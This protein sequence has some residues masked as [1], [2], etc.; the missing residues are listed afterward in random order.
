MTKPT[1]RHEV[2]NGTTVAAT[3]A[4]WYSCHNTPINNI[5]TRTASSRFAP[6]LIKLRIFLCCSSSCSGFWAIPTTAKIEKGRCSCTQSTGT[7]PMAA[8]RI[9]SSHTGSTPCPTANPSQQISKK[10]GSVA[11]PAKWIQRIGSDRNERI[12]ED[13]G[14]G[15]GRDKGR[16]WER[17]NQ[18]SP[19]PLVTAVAISAGT[20][21]THCLPLSPCPQRFP[22]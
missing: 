15:W 14:R 7:T 12:R 2:G 20:E 8:I 17:D 21:A 22:T 16:R 13:L 5:A 4:N 6:V 19:C 18:L 9:N 1:Q 3:G 10:I 11:N